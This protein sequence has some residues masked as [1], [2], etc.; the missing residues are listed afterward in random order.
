MK[1]K[2]N[3]SLVDYYKRLKQGK[4][5][6]E[7]HV[8]KYLQGNYLDNLDEFNNVIAA[9]NKNKMIS[10]EFNEWMAYQLADIS[11]H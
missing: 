2:Y 8:G 9:N 10:E 4:D 1:Q 3:E 7:L 11:Y 6:L 5:I